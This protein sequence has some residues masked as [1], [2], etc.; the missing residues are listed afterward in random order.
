MDFPLITTLPSLLPAGERVEQLPQI[1]PETSTLD[2]SSRKP[3]PPIEDPVSI[4]RRAY[5]EG[6]IQENTEIIPVTSGPSSWI[7]FPMNS[8]KA[9]YLRIAAPARKNISTIDLYV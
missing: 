2:W 9:L 8:A 6:E 3:Y 7:D 1:Y 4:S 5:I